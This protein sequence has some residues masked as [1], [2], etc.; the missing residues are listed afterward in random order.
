MKQAASRP[1]PPLPSAASGSSSSICGQINAMVGERGIHL[2]RQ[3]QVRQRIAQQPANEKFQAQIID[4]LGAR[5]V[6][7]AGGCHPPVDHLVAHRQDGRGKPVM[8]LGG[9]FILRHAVK[10]RIQ[11]P[12]GKW[13]Q[14]KSFGI[15]RHHIS[16][17]IQGLQTA[18]LFGKLIATIEQRL[19]RCF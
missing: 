16:R 4:P 15:E 8:G 5:S 18:C 1:R 6:H 19:P 9:A 12:V 17:A 10:Q 13:P 14:R 3:A 11:E 7:G 2:L